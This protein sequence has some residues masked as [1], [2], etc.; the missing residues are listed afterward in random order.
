MSP[1]ISSKIKPLWPTL[2]W[3]A[4]WHLLSVYLGSDLLLPSPVDVLIRLVELCGT[5]AFWLSILLTSGRIFAGFGLAVLLG[6]FF[7]VA[8]HRYDWIEALLRPPVAAMKS[9]PV[10]SFIILALVWVSTQ[11]LSVLIAFLMAF[12]LIYTNTY[13]GLQETDKQLLEMA[14]VFHVPYVRLL[15]GIVLPALTPY[16]R[17]GCTLAMGLCWKAGIAAEF[18]GLPKGTI[19]HALSDAKVYL[20]ISDLFAW[21]VAVVAISM[22]WERLVSLVLDSIFEKVVSI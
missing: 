15:R 5:A 14:Q 21:T 19:G 4:V 3:L 8:S 17:A 20:E 1:F 7:G 16:L 18:I 9:V 2:V 6:L 12:P 10:A 11:Q 13:A 22:V